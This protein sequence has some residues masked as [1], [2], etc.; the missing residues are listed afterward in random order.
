M[1]KRE[2]LAAIEADRNDHIALLQAFI[3]AP[4]PNPPGN[5]IA[6]AKVL[7]DYLEKSEIE[8]RI[9]APQ[10]S[11]PNIVSEFNG[12]GKGARVVMNGHIDVFPVANSDQWERN[13]WSGHFDGTYIH[14]RGVVDMKAG[15]AASVI[16]YTYLHRF[17]RHLKGSVALTAVSDE[18][19]GG[20]WGSK[21]LLEQDQERWGGDCMIDAEPGGLQSIRF[22]E[23]GTLRLT[24]TIHTVGAHGAY[25]HLSEGANRVAARLIKEL[26]SIE[27]IV[28]PNVPTLLVDYMKRADVRA[29]MDEMLGEGAAALALKPTINIGTLHGGAKVNMIPEQCIMETDIRLPIGLTRDVVLEHIHTILKGFPNVKMSIQE[30]A[31]NPA[32]YCSLDHPMLNAIA[33]NATAVN[34]RKPVGIPSLGATDTKFWR[35]LDIPAYIYG[36]SPATMATTDERALIEEFLAVIKIHAGAVWDHLEGPA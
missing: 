28:P 27:D 31:S 34:G 18:E 36:I 16:A 5:T 1:S 23:K 11:M 26:L 21:W 6:A 22:G 12:A 8:A 25:L 10:P 17:K 33:A 19:T 3:R 29:I 35:Y 7:C 30:A 24:F 9:L 4:S 15:T 13:P 20:K 14:G 2:L 32:S